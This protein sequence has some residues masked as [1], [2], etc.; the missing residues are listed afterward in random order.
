MNERVRM[1]VDAKVERVIRE[2]DYAPITMADKGKDN[3]SILLA[4][5]TLRR[6]HKCHVEYLENMDN[7]SIRLAGSTLR[8]P[9]K[10]HVEYLE[11]M[12]LTMPG[13]FPGIL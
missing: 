6:P 4:G 9:H 12:G 13:F 1:I 3:T 8:R 10:C 11:N 2:A 5:S 7:T